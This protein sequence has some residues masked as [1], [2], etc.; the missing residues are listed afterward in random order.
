MFRTIA[1]PLLRLLLLITWQLIRLEVSRK[2]VNS[3]KLIKRLHRIIQCWPKTDQH[4]T[5][6]TITL[7]KLS[8]YHV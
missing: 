1:D 6:W 7:S 3:D 2:L 4:L 8:R 5:I